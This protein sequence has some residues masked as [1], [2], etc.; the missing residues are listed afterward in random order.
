MRLIS[1]VLLLVAAQ[2]AHSQWEYSP[3]YPNSIYNIN[4]GNVG[5]GTSSPG[6]PL[7][8][9][10]NQLVVGGEV[11]VLGSPSAGDTQINARGD[12]YSELLLSGAWTPGAASHLLLGVW[13]ASGYA[14][15]AVFPTG[16][17]AFLPFGLLVGGQERI[18]VATTGD[19]GIG[20]SSPEARMHVVGGV[21]I[22]GDLEVQGTTN[23]VPRYQP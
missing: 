5:I 13:P 9:Y 12:G 17:T 7:A 23:L 11:P 8:V 21:K 10:G 2:S 4:S 16:P 14:G 1:L 15:M 19:V 22:T 6:A 20:T 18:W 3:S